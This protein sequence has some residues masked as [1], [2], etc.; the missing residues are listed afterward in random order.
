MRE[1]GLFAFVEK[2]VR[3]LTDVIMACNFILIAS[4]VFFRYVLKDPIVWSE[5]LAKFMLVWMVYLYASTTIRH[6]ENI[7]VTTV[8]EKLPPKAN[9]IAEFILKIIAFAFISFLFVLALK[10]IPAVWTH[11]TAPALGILMV[12]PE[13][14]IIVGLGL[15]VLQFLG[16]FIDTIAARPA[17][18]S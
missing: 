16:L 10:S 5:E 4:S 6:W 9:W 8:I 18:R 14:A 1:K 2:V 17:K 11:E 15:M 7:R 13:L 12:I 3:Y